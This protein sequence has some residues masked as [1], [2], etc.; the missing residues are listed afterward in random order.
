[1]DE[2]S[3]SISSQKKINDKKEIIIFLNKKLLSLIIFV[4]IL[5][6]YMKIMKIILLQIE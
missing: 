2:S 3:Y 6:L 1:M 4:F 5:I